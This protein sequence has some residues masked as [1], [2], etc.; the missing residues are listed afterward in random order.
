MSRI[1]IFTLVGNR[2]LSLISHIFLPHIHHMKSD[3]QQHSA[4]LSHFPGM[5]LTHNPTCSQSPEYAHDKAFNKSL[6][7]CFRLPYSVFPSVQF[8]LEVDPEFPVFDELAHTHELELVKTYW[9]ER[10]FMFCLQPSMRT[11]L[12]PLSH[13]FIYLCM[14]VCPVLPFLIWLLFVFFKFLIKN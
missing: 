2:L 9:E 13:F 14:F 10:K 11:A 12:W 8:A 6:L 3:S 1:L 7:F 5:T 4:L